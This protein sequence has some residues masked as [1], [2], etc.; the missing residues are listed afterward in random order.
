MKL[1]YRLRLHPNLTRNDSMRVVVLLLMGDCERLVFL[2]PPTGGTFMR[3]VCAH[4]NN[5]VQLVGRMLDEMHPVAICNDTICNS[6]VG[7]WEGAVSF[8]R[9]YSRITPMMD[10]ESLSNA[11][12]GSSVRGISVMKRMP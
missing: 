5:R 10:L 6:V 11:D 2:L 3:S 4:K 7:Y 8:A 1:G 9:S 12:A